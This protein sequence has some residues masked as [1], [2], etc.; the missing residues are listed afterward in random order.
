MYKEEERVKGRGGSEV[1]EENNHHQCQPQE[2]RQQD[3]EEGQGMAAVPTGLGTKEERETKCEK[4]SHSN[5][6]SI[7]KPG[8]SHHVDRIIFFAGGWQ[9]VVSQ[10]LSYSIA[11]FALEGLHPQTQNSLPLT[12]RLRLAQW[13]HSGVEGDSVTRFALPTEWSLPVL[14]TGVIH[15]SQIPGRQGIPTTVPPGAKLN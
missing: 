10:V 5:H 1:E 2:N 6:G 4:S 11:R 14:C 12:V 15:V 7:L 8:V 13:T 9:F 3:G